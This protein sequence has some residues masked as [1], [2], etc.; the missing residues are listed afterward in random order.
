MDGLIVDA[1][2]FMVQNLPLTHCATDMLAHWSSSNRIYVCCRCCFFISMHRARIHGVHT[3]FDLYVTGACIHLSFI[4]CK[5]CVHNACTRWETATR[6]YLNFSKQS[7]TM[8]PSARGAP[9]HIWICAKLIPPPFDI[10]LNRIYENSLRIEPDC[11]MLMMVYSRH[12]GMFHKVP[13][14]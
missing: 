4:L 12:F 5:V 6:H 7:L 1:E 11:I 8:V 14:P 2:W 3:V 10:D 13:S 9:K